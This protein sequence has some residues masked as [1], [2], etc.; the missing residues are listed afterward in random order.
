MW[1]CLWEWNSLQPWSGRGMGMGARSRLAQ[2]WSAIAEAPLGEGGGG[3]WVSRIPLMFRL[4][5]PYSYNSCRL[6]PLMPVT[7]NDVMACNIF[8][9]TYRKTHFQGVSSFRIEEMRANKVPRIDMSTF[10]RK[11]TN[12]C[13]CKYLFISCLRL[14]YWSINLFYSVK[15]CHFYVQYPQIS[16]LNIPY[17]INFLPKYPVSPKIFP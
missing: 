16:Y 4:N 13:I 5:I 12:N 8:R 6:F 11:N 7:S 9:T 15:T 3:V 1:T 2:K 14:P 10:D 17:S